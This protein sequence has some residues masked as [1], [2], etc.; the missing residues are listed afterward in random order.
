MKP[1]A[2]HSRS[3]RIGAIAAKEKSQ[4]RRLIP[5][6]RHPIPQSY[7][8]LPNCLGI[9]PAEPLGENLN[10]SNPW[11]LSQAHASL[12]CSE[13]TPHDAQNQIH[14]VVDVPKTDA[15]IPLVLPYAVVRLSG[16]TEIG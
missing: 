7:P 13:C 10:A 15:A 2:H 4:Q 1:N 5:D 11:A 14:H 16:G 3:E 12:G 8:L 6:P 9:V